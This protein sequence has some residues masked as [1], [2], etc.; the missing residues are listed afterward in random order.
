MTLTLAQCQPTRTLL[1]LSAIWQN[2]AE[3]CE[4]ASFRLGLT[5]VQQSVRSEWRSQ[6]GSQL[7][8]KTV[9]SL[10]AI[11]HKS[12]TSTATKFEMARPISPRKCFLLFLALCDLWP[13][14][15]HKDCILR[16]HLAYS[17]QIGK[18][19]SNFSKKVF[20]SIFFSSIWPLTSST[21]TLKM[22]ADQRK[23]PHANIFKMS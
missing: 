2:C 15:W 20:A 8:S 6:D 22:A 11:A 23:M 17:Y 4:I 12:E 10:P 21:D 13:L 18:G 5:R 3:I 19:L 7:L 16:L 1:C 14:P 9:P